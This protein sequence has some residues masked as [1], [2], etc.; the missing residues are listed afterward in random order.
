M[1]VALVSLL[2]GFGYEAYVVVGRVKS[3]HFLC[4][5]VGNYTIFSVR[6][7]GGAGWL[8]NVQC[9]MF[10]FNQLYSSR[11]DI[12]LFVHLTAEPTVQCTVYTYLE[13]CVFYAPF[14]YHSLGQ[15]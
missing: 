6:G 1:S 3:C 5:S 4:S 9:T 7:G 12:E 11:S 8:H 10:I 14:C 13:V 2:R 15:F